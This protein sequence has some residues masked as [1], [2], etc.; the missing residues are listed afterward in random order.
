MKYGKQVPASCSLQIQKVTNF[1][2]GC[3]P[4]DS[5][6]RASHPAGHAINRIP[7]LPLRR[8]LADE[9]RV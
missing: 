2:S 8:D 4:A 6:P 5:P 1:D 3:M 7:D 9:Y